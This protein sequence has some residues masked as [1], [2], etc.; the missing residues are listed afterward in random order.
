MSF[1]KIMTFKK[2]TPW[3]GKTYKGFRYDGKVIVFSKG[4]PEVIDY[5]YASIEIDEKDNKFRITFSNDTSDNTL[6]IVNYNG[7]NPRIGCRCNMPIGKY[8][9]DQEDKNIFTFIEE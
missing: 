9:Q 3:A 6:Y 8:L 2:L 5:H 1:H 7:S 4:L